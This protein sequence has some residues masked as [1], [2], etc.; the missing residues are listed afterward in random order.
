M[1]FRRIAIDRSLAA[2]PIDAMGDIIGPGVI[3]CPGLSR[4]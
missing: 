2:S 4:K 3:R 1:L